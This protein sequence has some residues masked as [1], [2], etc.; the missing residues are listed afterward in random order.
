MDAV[1]HA[2]IDRV[3]ESEDAAAPGW[4]AARLPGLSYPGLV[5][6]AAATATGRVYRDLDAREWAV[7]DAFENPDYTV[8]VVELQSGRRAFAYVWPYKARDDDWTV[9]SLDDEEADAY[10]TRCA[11]WRARHEDTSLNCET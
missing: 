8:E 2:L 11:A 7:L 9:S 6:D 3:P 5:A 4:R 10:L 1:V